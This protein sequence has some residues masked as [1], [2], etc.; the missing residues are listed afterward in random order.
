ML[1]ARPLGGH[2]LLHGVCGSEHVHV[3]AGAA[4]SCGGGLGQLHAADHG[5]R[6]RRGL[7][8]RAALRPPRLEPAQTSETASE[9][10]LGSVLQKGAATLHAGRHHA[11]CWQQPALDIHATL[12]TTCRRGRQER[13]R[14][15]CAYMLDHASAAGSAAPLTSAVGGS[16]SKLLH[17]CMPGSATLR[18]PR[19]GSGGAA[20]AAARRPSDARR[21]SYAGL[22]WMNTQRTASASS[23]A[24]TAYPCHAPR[25]A[26]AMQHSTLAN[27]HIRTVRAPPVASARACRCIRVHLHSR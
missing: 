20:P 18:A 1:G 11:A 13:M 16:I 23:S 24:A 26:H 7:Q 3:G 10:Q 6:L 15:W 17:T 5:E 25:H 4:A 27:P 21:P 2:G 8:A 19:G 9:K 12:E 14:N 22:S